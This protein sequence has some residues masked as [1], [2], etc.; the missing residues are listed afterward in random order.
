MSKPL[1]VYGATEL[2]KM[3]YFDSLDDPDFKIVAFATT[4]E[5]L[6]SDTFVG[7]PLISINEAQALY[8]S[9]HYDIITAVGGYSDMRAHTKY[10]Y[11]AKQLG[12]EL[13][14]YVSK[15]AFISPGTCVAENSM[16]L[17]FTFVGADVDI[18]E[19][20]I[21]RQNCYLGHHTAIKPH[22]FIGIGCTIGGGS[23]IGELS[24]I[25]MG[26][27]IVDS[28]KI[29]RETLVGAGSV[30]LSDTQAYVKVVGNPARMIGSHEE[31][32]IRIKKKNG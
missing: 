11:H 2:S 16:I 7:L 14:S 24:Y 9:T 19:N 3:L 13:R 6:T 20:V 5:Y 10:F 12:Y 18:Q 29:G 25:A 27:V 28:I 30:V 23:E 4:S 22:A 17:P 1:I 26:A 8:P 32:G 21:V 15:R 31:E